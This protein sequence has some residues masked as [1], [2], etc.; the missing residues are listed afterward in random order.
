MKGKL[1]ILRFLALILF[2]LKFNEI[3]ARGK[4]RSLDNQGDDDENEDSLNI[5][6]VPEPEANVTGC[7][8][9]KAIL[10]HEIRTATQNQFPFMASIMSSKNEYVCAGTVIANGLILTTAQ[11][12]D[13]ISYVLVNGTSD[14]KDDTTF[15]LHVIKSENFPSYTGPNTGKD[16]AVIYTEKHNNTLASKITLSNYTS[17]QLLNDV[18]VLGFGLNAEVG[19]PKK[20][21]FVGLEAR[22]KNEDVI[23]AYIDCIETKVSTCFRD[24]GGPVLFNNEL[25][26]IVTKGQP[27]CTAEILSTYAL[28]KH[29]V[30]ALP[31]Y[32]FKAWIDEKIAKAAEPGVEALEAYPKKPSYR[33]AVIHI[34]TSSA[35][36]KSNN[37]VFITIAYTL[38]LYF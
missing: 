6:D 36:L 1:S 14:K 24:K 10:M 9:K 20:L 18:E 7:T 19:Q 35:Y 2:L 30:D 37:V 26:G 4:E 21:Q 5:A 11:C 27:E 29:M 22:E 23:R 38:V 17:A 28:N 25:V 13:S 8:R 33:E 32:S 34:M 31:T 12:T 15:S 16:V 3:Y